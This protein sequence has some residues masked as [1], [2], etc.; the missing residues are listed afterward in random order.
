M[1]DLANHISRTTGV[2][3]EVDRQVSTGKRTSKTSTDDQPTTN[4]SSNS[5]NSDDYGQHHNI[6]LKD[7]TAQ[8]GQSHMAKLPKKCFKTVRTPILDEE[9]E[10]DPNDPYPMHSVF[11]GRFLSGLGFKKNRVI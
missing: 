1:K 9:E 10:H 8:L 4:D 3:P 2:V 5:V 11:F 6:N 7:L